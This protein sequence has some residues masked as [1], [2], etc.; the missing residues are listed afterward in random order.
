VARAG[1]V[2]G[3]KVCWEILEFLNA[4]ERDFG[5]RYQE[6]M[7]VGPIDC[8]RKPQ[9]QNSDGGWLM[10]S[11][12]GHND[13]TTRLVAVAHTSSLSQTQHRA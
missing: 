4:D 1:L 3:R 7:P 11:R 10:N 12:L 13:G 8:F 2:R 5:A 9:R 6:R